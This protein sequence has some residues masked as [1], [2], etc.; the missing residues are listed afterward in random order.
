VWLGLI[1]LGVAA[2]ACVGVGLLWAG[3]PAELP[4]D[5]DEDEPAAPD[6]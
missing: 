4:A 5:E 6:R 2:L 3:R 1:G